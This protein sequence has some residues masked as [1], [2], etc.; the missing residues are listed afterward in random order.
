MSFNHTD[1]LSTF[2]YQV[3]ALPGRNV[4]AADVTI[5]GE[6]VLSERCSASGLTN[7]RFCVPNEFISLV[8]AAEQAA[9]VPCELSLSFVN[10]RGATVEL[11]VPMAIWSLETGQSRTDTEG[12]DI[13]TDMQFDW[14]DIVTLDNVLAFISGS[15]VMEIPVDL[16]LKNPLNFP[17]VIQAV[18]LDLR[19]KDLDGSPD[20]WY[21]PGPA[22]PIN[23]EEVMVDNFRYTRDFSVGGQAE[24]TVGM[25]MEI[26][27]SRRQELSNRLY[28]DYYEKGRLCLQL[29]NA[30]T[31][32]R[33]QHGSDPAL[34]MQQEFEK[35]DIGAFGFN[36][37]GTIVECTPDTYELRNYRFS[38]RTADWQRNGAAVWQN[39]TSGG[40]Y[41]LR[42]TSGASTQGSAYLKTQLLVTE[43]WVA[44]FR[45]HAESIW[46]AV[47]DGTGWALILQD[48][49]AT[50]HVSG[51]YAYNGLPGRSVAVVVDSADDF[52]GVAVD[53]AGTAFIGPVFSWGEF[54]SQ[55][56]DNDWHT[57]EVTYTR[58]ERV[59]RVYFDSSLKLTQ[60]IDLATYFPGDMAY[61]GLGASANS[62]TSAY[63]ASLN[64]VD[65]FVWEGNVV[66][67]AQSFVREAGRTVAVVRTAATVVIDSR[68]SCGSPLYV[69]GVSWTI[70]L[71]LQGTT[72][73]LS[74]GITVFDTQDGYY[75]VTFTASIAG[76]YDV[77]A[78][79]ALT[80]ESGSLGLV[81][82]S[83]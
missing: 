60:E 83:A 59:L 38:G 18:G 22:Y 37:C 11:L 65:T 58:A 70:S 2:P 19:L 27:G 7:P 21:I 1:Q 15:Q 9:G 28:D 12:I 33:I 36:P 25:T 72:T 34:I 23:W 79:L 54:D 78:D 32:F 57:V 31:E 44:R 39:P 30:Y 64:E 77:W 29:R 71:K 68:D 50:N 62:L 46:N 42:F 80:G 66:S 8:I 52:I 75:T 51:R 76:T 35:S 41:G 61:V 67:V 20:F 49:S 4:L 16:T 81:S 10:S 74:S 40:A 45:I 13:L 43:N 69:G 24:V 47:Y 14:S 6:E 5:F 73:V 55:P 26:P 63:G 48:T 53:G 17:L 56:D 82:I 3:R